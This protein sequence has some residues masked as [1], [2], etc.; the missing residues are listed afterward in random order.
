MV[1]SPMAEPK[2]S[3]ALSGLVVAETSISSIDADQGILTYR[4]YDIADL[5]EHA[6]YEEVV[7][8][9]LEGELPEDDQLAV[10]EEELAAT[11]VLPASVAA[12]VDTNAEVAGSTEML[13]TAVSALSFSD[14]AEE[15][16]DAANERRKAVAL[17][18]QLP[19]IIARYDRRR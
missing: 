12:I 18:A 7:Y 4:G 2:K 13:R 11:R 19:T 3:V 10:F 8:L 1:P 5:G 9:L 16:I 17:V 15:A 14:P 6:S